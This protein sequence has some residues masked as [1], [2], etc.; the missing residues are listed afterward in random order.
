MKPIEA[1][2]VSAPLPAEGERATGAT[3]G[4]VKG[5]PPTD[6]QAFYAAQEEAFTDLR[7]YHSSRARR[8]R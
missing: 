2:P 6:E 1:P 8:K 7:A 3:G 5:S 4:Q